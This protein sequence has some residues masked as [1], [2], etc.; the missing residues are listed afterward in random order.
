MPNRIFTG[1]EKA[2]IAIGASVAVGCQP[3]TEHHIKSVGRAV[4]GRPPATGRRAPLGVPA[5]FG[6]ASLLENLVFGAGAYDPFSF[7]SGVLLLCAARY[8][9]AQ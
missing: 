9:W 7:A 6:F 2:L 8:R 4:P 1:N 5:A 3:C